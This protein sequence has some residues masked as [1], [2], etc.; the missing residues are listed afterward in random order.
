MVETNPFKHLTHLSLKLVAGSD[1]ALKKH[2]AQC[3]QSLKVCTASVLNSHSIL[4]RAMCVH[5]CLR[6]CVRVCAYVCV[7]V[8]VSLAVLCCCLLL[9]V[10]N[11]LCPVYHDQSRSQEGRL[12]IS[13]DV[14]HD[15]TLTYLLVFIILTN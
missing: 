14:E 5:A 2:L 11:I 1:S 12:H 8:C 3:V 4:C 6:A 10:A 13:T 15:F 9:S 7:C